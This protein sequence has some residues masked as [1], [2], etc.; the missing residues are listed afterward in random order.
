VPTA[1]SLGDVG[2]ID[3]FPTAIS[4][5]HG[6]AMASSGITGSR[7]SDG[8]LV[9][10]DGHAGGST[11]RNLGDVGQFNTA[12]QMSIHPKI[13]IKI[14]YGVVILEDY[15]ALRKPSPRTTINLGDVGKVLII[16]GSR[17]SDG[18]SVMLEGHAR[19]PTASNRGDVGQ[20]D[21]AR[22]ATTSGISPDNGGS[23]ILEGHAG[24]STARNRG[25]VGQ[26]DAA[27]IATECGM[28]PSFGG[29]VILQGHAHIMTAKSIGNVGQ[30]NATCIA[31][32]TSL[33]I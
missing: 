23:V 2:H 13:H 6:N 16:R 9:I 15:A 31:T 26:V 19:A 27:R 8:G 17:P 5:Y 32:T 28:S 24:G 10:L 21:A 14:E 4:H 12:R 22:I 25:D 3:V 7:P 29:A 11:A 1:R 33:S 30:V 20:V 18:G